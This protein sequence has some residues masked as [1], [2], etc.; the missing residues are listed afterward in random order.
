MLF[1]DAVLSIQ[2][3]ND[4]WEIGAQLLPIPSNSHGSSLTDG[5]EKQHAGKGI[6]A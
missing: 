4:G 6:R 3:G 2:K 5:C 1:H